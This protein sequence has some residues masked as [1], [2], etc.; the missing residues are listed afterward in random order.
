MILSP[1]LGPDSKM[2]LSPDE[3]KQ[4]LQTTLPSE[5]LIR[6]VVHTSI[7]ELE[8]EMEE[9]LSYRVKSGFLNQVKI[10]IM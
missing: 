9:K 1:V 5:M 7:R 8:N 6:G 10:K 4:A 3:V 2:D